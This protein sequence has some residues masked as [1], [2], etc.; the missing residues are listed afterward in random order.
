M[1]EKRC[2]HNVLMG[3]HEEKDILE[4]QG[5]DGRIISKWVFKKL[6]EGLDWMDLA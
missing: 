3:V 6:D 1:R 2:V 5:V 4:D